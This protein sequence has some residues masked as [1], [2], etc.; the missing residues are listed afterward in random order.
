MKT[1]FLKTIGLT[2]CLGGLAA[3]AFA[4]GD[5]AAAQNV[6]VP[7]KLPFSIYSD[8]ADHFI[9][10]GYMGD[11][12][13]IVIISSCKQKPAQGEKCMKVKYSAKAAQGANWAGVFWQDPANNWGTVKGAGYNLTG[14]KKVKF[15][16]RGDKGGESIEF[17][18]G[19]I[20]GEHP[21]TF[22]ADAPII[23]LTAEWQELE[24]DLTEQDLNTVIGGFC[25]ALAK[26]KN[27]EGCV[28]YLDNIRY[29]P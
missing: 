29:E 18:A 17:K 12:S 6:K 16:A 20:S 4:Q 2:F 5:P 21:D 24:I 23:T 1:R 13:D 11:T 25:F 28:F 9:P 26:D 10:S 27:P 8:N 14:A 3:A 15:F 22:K 7:Q 19:G